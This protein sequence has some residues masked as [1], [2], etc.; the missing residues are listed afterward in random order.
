MREEYWNEFCKSGKI[1]DYLRYA[2]YD[3]NKSLMQEVQ[4]E[5]KADAGF[6]HDN[7]NSSKD[8]THWGI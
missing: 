2:G 4:V 3:D 1:E 7:G 6:Y 5:G 8:G